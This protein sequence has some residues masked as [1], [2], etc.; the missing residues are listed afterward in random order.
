MEQ[1]KATAL[2]V[3]VM[4]LLFGLVRSILPAARYEKYMRLILCLIF[5]VMLI[6]SV[7]RL[8][9]SETLL[10][11]FGEFE[12]SH[13]DISEQL[14]S[15]VCTYLNDS[16]QLA[17]LEAVCISAL[18][19]QVGETYSVDEITVLL[20]KENQEQ[21]L[22]RLTELTGLREEQIYVKYT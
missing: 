14:E 2:S 8:F 11:D 1:L 7:R 17:G 5:L 4:V 21:A 12:F 16:L 18:I 6:G 20:A 22:I 3:C 19:S 9:I 10:F 13:N 15:A